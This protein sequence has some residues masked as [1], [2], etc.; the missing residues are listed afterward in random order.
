MTM[1]TARI[2]RARRGADGRLR[3]LTKTGKLGRPIRERLDVTRLDEPAA[4]E[5]DEDTPVLTRREL[6]DLRPAVVTTT[7]DVLALRRRLR[8]SQGAFAALFGIPLAT[9]KDWEQ[10]RRQ[11]D[12]PARAYLR[13]IARD[14]GAVR[15]A[16]TMAAE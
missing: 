5:P 8:L 3:R 4:F 13:V 14:P 1:K 12:A 2:V 15:R 10:G 9:L 16:L 6:R 11:P 7:I